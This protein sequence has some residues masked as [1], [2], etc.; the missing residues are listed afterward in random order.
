MGTKTM[1]GIIVEEG[2]CDNS[3]KFK[4]RDIGPLTY[5]KFDSNRDALFCTTHDGEAFHEAARKKPSTV[6]YRVWS[7]DQFTDRDIIVYD[8]ELLYISQ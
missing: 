7:V 6:T 8:V 4:M 1:S 2:W 5:F 3:S